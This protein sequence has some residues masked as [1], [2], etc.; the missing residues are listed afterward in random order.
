MALSAVNGE[1]DKAGG[2]AEG[3]G[4]LWG[5]QGSP[6]LEDSSPRFALTNRVTLGKLLASWE[7]C[8]P[9]KGGKGERVS[10]M[11]L[12]SAPWAT[13]HQLHNL[14]QVTASVSPSVK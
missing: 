5:R 10:Q 3:R 12:L 11:A 7:L 2:C 9:Q 4:G 8:F 13:T 1:G 6:E 14:G